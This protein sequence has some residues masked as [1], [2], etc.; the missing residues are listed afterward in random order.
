MRKSDTIVAEIH[1]IRHRIDDETEGMTSEQITAYFRRSTAPIIEK[2][3]ITTVSAAELR[4]C[5]RN[6]TSARQ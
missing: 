2:Y 5:S 1:K 6:L 4:G 3:G